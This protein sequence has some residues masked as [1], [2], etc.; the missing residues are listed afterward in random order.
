MP[1]GIQFLID[2][3]ALLDYDNAECGYVICAFSEHVGKVV[4]PANVAQTELMTVK[5]SKLRQ[6][7]VEVFDISLSQLQQATVLSG[8]R[9]V[10]DNSCLVIAKEEGGAVITS[11]KRLRKRCHAHC[12]HV[13][14]AL[15]MVVEVVKVHALTKRKAQSVLASFHRTDPYFYTDNLIKG[16]LEQLKRI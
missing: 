11:D 9:D 8:P 15:E 14:W 2:A 4:V 7:G 12:I 13:L 1:K 16:Y 3:N 10:R 5:P 6:W